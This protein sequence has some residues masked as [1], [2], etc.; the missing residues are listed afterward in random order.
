MTDTQRL[1]LTLPD[2]TAVAAIATQPCPSA[3]P[4]AAYVFA[5]GAGAGMEH[6]F[7]KDVAQGLARRRIAC[8]RYQFPYMQAGKRR[9]DSPATA[10]ATVRA[11]VALAHERWPATPLFAGGKSFGGRMSSQAQAQSPLPGVRGLVFLGFPLHPAGK[12]SVARAEHLAAIQIPMLFI[13]GS[14]DAL[15]EAG[16]YASMQAG[17]AGI[18]SCVDIAGADHGFAVLR[19]SGRTDAEAL[20]EALDALLAWVLRQ[21]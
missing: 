11:A 15:A 3:A 12:P 10:H 2:G 1:D 21:R 17:L 9:V 13:R 16:P 19:R 7:M 5:H 14:R 4:L 6:A 18:A 8:L 20:D